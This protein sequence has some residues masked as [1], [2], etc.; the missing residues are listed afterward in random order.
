[1]SPPVT[2]LTLLLHLAVS[3]A[4]Y[5]GLTQGDHGCDRDVKET[6]DA[7]FFFADMLVLD[8]FHWHEIPAGTGFQD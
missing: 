3:A 6:G 1:M 4:P 5:L 7:C 8:A 2:T